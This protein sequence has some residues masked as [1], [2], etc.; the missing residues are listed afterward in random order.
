M[1]CW[2]ITLVLSLLVFGYYS[3]FILAEHLNLSLALNTHMHIC[4]VF[5]VHFFSVLSTLMSLSF[6]VTIIVIIPAELS[7][8]L[9]GQR[10]SWGWNSGLSLTVLLAGDSCGWDDH[11]STCTFW[12]LLSLGRSVASMGKGICGCLESTFSILSFLQLQI[13]WSPPS[14]ATIFL[15]IIDSDFPGMTSLFSP[16]FPESFLPLWLPLLTLW[17]PLNTGLLSECPPFCRRLWGVLLPLFF[18]F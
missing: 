15:P 5:F 13:S 10:Q 7:P 3:K 16:A 1:G 6:L 18:P 11:G 8:G 9:K 17:P 14:S 4:S 12:P 2:E